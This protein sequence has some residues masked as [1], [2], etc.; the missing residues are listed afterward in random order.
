MKRYIRIISIFCCW[1]VCGGCMSLWAQTPDDDAA[2]PRYEIIGTDTLEYIRLHTI[3]VTPKGKRKYPERPLTTAE[4]RELWRMIRD[5]R[6][7]LPIAKELTRALIET[8]EY[9]ETLPNDKARERHLK[10]LESSLKEQYEPQMRDLTLRQ[11]KMLIKLV[12]RQ[13]NQSSYKI[14]KAFF[15]GWKAFW[16][17]GFANLFGASLKTDYDPRYN[18]MDALTERIVRLI[19]DQR[20]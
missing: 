20:L 15:G 18:K 4:R 16:W 7:T 14:V 8:Y 5:I 12:A 6:K 19:E 2:I 9:I 11:G 17:N 10:L 1:I 3:V 13:A